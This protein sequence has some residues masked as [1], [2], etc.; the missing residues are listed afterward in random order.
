MLCTKS[1]KVGRGHNNG[2]SASELS[3]KAQD[4][5]TVPPELWTFSHSNWFDVRFLHILNV[6]SIAFVLSNKNIQLLQQVETM[7]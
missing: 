5:S 7:E 1:S 2:K 6:D 4:L 3:K